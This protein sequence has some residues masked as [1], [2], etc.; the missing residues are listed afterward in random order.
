MPG[1]ARRNVEPKPEESPVVDNPE[2]ETTENDTTP[3]TDSTVE[4]SKEPE[5]NPV[6]VPDDWEAVPESEGGG[7]RPKTVP[8]A[9]YEGA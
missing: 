5:T 9:G 6:V 3:E 4:E 8:W 2:N 1:T 7:I